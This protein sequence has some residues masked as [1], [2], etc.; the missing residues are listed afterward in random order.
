M[1][2]QEKEFEEATGSGLGSFATLLLYKVKEK[3][4]AA[5]LCVQ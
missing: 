5:D 2:Q 4:R 3:Q 1:C